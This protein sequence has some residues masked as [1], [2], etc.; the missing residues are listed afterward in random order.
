MKLFFIVF[1]GLNILWACS[2]HEVTKDSITQATSLT[3]QQKINTASHNKKKIK[4]T[5]PKEKVHFCLIVGS[6]TPFPLYGTI[7]IKKY[8]KSLKS[9]QTPVGS[10][11]ESYQYTKK[12]CYLAYKYCRVIRCG[13]EPIVEIDLN[14]KINNPK[15]L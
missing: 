9:F 13:S 15:A 12:H 8:K 6:D 11:S 14:S 4:L 1:I 5:T 7:D 3:K 2:P 10:L